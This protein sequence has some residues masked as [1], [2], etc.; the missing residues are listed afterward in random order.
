MSGTQNRLFRYTSLPVLLHSLR[1]K[2]LTLLDPKTWEDKNDTHFL[3][4]YR[5]LCSAKTLLAIC[6]TMRS[7]RFH[8]WKVF[9]NDIG[10]VCIAF[11][12]DELIK[13][14]PVAENL[15]HGPVMYPEIKDLKSTPLSLS[16]MP[17]LK[18]YP[19][20]DE[21]EYRIIF[22]DMNEVLE[23]KSFPINLSCIASVRINPWL[24]STLVRDVRATIK[25]IDGC[26]GIRVF[27]TT[28]LENEEWK[29]IAEQMHS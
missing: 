25:A 18:R 12:K 20:K 29:K 11:K 4:R 8:H 27:Q 6:F 10:G 13:S 1:T 21:K 23:Q 9:S 22:K 15:V 26:K 2:A 5:Q 24:H 19:Y 3:E 16:K 7:E 14:F 17:F 28:V